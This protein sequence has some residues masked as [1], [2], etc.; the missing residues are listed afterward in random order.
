MFRTHIA[1]FNGSSRD[2]GVSG[3]ICG[4]LYKQAKK[5]PEVFRSIAK[6]T[7]IAGGS[8]E[9]KPFSRRLNAFL[10]TGACGSLFGLS[11]LLYR[12]DPSHGY[13]LTVGASSSLATAS[14]LSERR[15]SE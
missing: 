5:E 8:G 6:S 12:N 9:F 10:H 4:H 2:V 15:H 7:A 1:R 14:F 3:G 11:V 13:L